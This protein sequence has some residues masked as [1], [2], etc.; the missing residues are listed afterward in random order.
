MLDTS[1]NPSPAEQDGD[2]FAARHIMP[3]LRV[4]QG[5][6]APVAGCDQRARS[7]SSLMWFPPGVVSPRRTPGTASV[8]PHCLRRLTFCYQMAAWVCASVQSHIFHKSSNR[9]RV[10]RRPDESANS[11]NVSWI[12]SSPF[13]YRGFLVPMDALQGCSLGFRET[14]FSH[15]P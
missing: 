13:C 8:L 10:D 11:K 6:A 1:L 15:S 4:I 9:R 2:G 3:G 12:Y 14:L 7:V 5:I